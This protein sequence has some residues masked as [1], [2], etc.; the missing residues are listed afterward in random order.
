MLVTAAGIVID[1]KLL[2]RKNA[3]FPISVTESGILYNVRGLPLGY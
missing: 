2:A 3:L 1:V